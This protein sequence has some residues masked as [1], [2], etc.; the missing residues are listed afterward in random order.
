LP[1][2]PTGT[3][4]FLFTDIEGSTRLLEE[5]GDRYAEVLGEHRRVLREAL[6]RHHG[7]EVDTQG[8]AFFVAFERASD[9]VE[10]AEEAQRALELPVRMGIHTGEPALGSEGYVGMDVHRAARICAAAHGRQVV[11]SEA[12]VRLL[13]VE[14][15]DLGEHR[16]KDFGE[17]ARLFQLG[18]E[19]FPPLRTIS[20]TNLPRP[21]SSFVGREKEVRDV[22]ARLAEG[23]RLL[24]LTGPGGTGKTRLAIEAAAELVPE[25]KAGAFWV[26]L[27][28]L[29]DPGLVVETISE[30]LGA[31][32]GL[33]E[34]IGERE[35]LL[36]LD[37][38]EQVV[39][40]APQL[41]SLIEQCP[42][43]TLLVTSRELLRV[44]GEVEYAVSP[45][46][47]PEAVRLFCARSRLEA[48]EAVH[49]LC[50]R[51]DY[52]PLALEL[53]AARTTVLSPQQILERLS[54]RLDLLKGGRDAEA[55][56]LTL[57][58]TIE[59]SHELLT[60]TERRLF[61]RLAV[62]AGGCTLEA[63]EDV[64]D[65]NLDTLQ[66]LVDKSLVRHT[67]E[68]FWMLETIRELA[69]E[70]L[71]QAGEG[72]GLRRR[73][74]DVLQELAVEAEPHLVEASQVEWLERIDAERDN[75]RAALDWALEAG[76]PQRALELAAPLCRFWWVRAPAEGLGWLERGL[77]G[78]GVSPRVRAEALD[79]AGGCAWFVGDHERALRLFEQGL[80]IYRELGDRRGIGMMLNRLGP[81]LAAAGRDEESDRVVEEAAGIHRELGDNSE[82]TLSLQ[83]L[84]SHAME[85][86]DLQKATALL[87]ESAV[88]SRESGNV[89]FLVY[90][91]ANLAE[92]AIRS[93]NLEDANRY[94]REQVA[95]A[96]ELGDQVSTLFALALRAIVVNRRGEFE[97]AGALWGAVER[98]DAVLGESMWRNERATYEELLGDRD[99]AFERG[100]EAGRKLPLEDAVALAL[101]P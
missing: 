19:T 3:V 25:F 82:L 94:G 10:A 23:A 53:A 92:V 59:W 71:E 96:N 32:N 63:A 30:T 7:V 46:A 72:A 36:L 4:T 11:V 9:A 33:A 83:I 18:D 2:L 41:A 93:G 60:E 61:A 54:H 78:E 16:L 55:R 42:H 20:N 5:L 31:K 39:E 76:V 13:D 62:F 28:P 58:A 8:D 49:E 66:S 89:H 75:V 100:V 90:S 74:F 51:L 43:L 80:A 79:A 57:R 47:E 99:P 77:S 44:R 85:L 37:N 69:L 56:Q 14:L 35:L 21:A 6:E 86:G 70:R 91:V 97:R 101:E 67:G 12:T 84:G 50:R 95:L 52:L 27:A 40:A 15:S 73:H 68:R 22:V 38:F 98:L 17:P 87:E 88:F 65:A 1:E 45:L 81:P 34:H 26:G 29:R 48:D 64:A 24:T